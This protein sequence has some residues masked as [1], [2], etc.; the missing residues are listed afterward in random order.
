M[1]PLSIIV[2]MLSL[3]LPVAVQDTTTSTSTKPLES[4]VGTVAVDPVASE[5]F[6]PQALAD[7]LVGDAPPASKPVD[8]DAVDPGA[9]A[10]KPAVARP[11]RARLNSPVSQLAPPTQASWWQAP[12]LRVVGLLLVM[13]VAAWMLKRWKVGLG[14]SAPGRPSGVMS[15]LARYPFGRGGSLVLVECG[16]KIVMLHQHAGRGGDVTALSEFTT[17]EDVALLRTRLGAVEREADPAFA[18]DL[19]TQLGAYDRNGR[20]VGS[21]GMPT[22]PE[23]TMEMVDLTRRRPR[24]GARNA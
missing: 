3:A 17:P 22:T 24:Q 19:Q 16:P 4:G 13:G 6:D 7:R 1:D 2:V 10:S 21:T 15:V 8:V 11:L 23:G 5:P 20:T 14:V 12:E 9:D 18:A